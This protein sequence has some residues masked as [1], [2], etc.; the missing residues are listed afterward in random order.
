MFEYSFTQSFWCV[1]GN[2]LEISSS[3]S[4]GKE[5]KT[6]LEP[7]SR[8]ANIKCFTCGGEVNRSS[9]YFICVNGC[10]GDVVG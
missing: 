2:Q 3:N 9:G 8:C 6:I 4:D 1:C 7:C 5:T 10:G